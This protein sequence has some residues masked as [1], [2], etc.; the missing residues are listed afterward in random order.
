MQHNT[1]TDLVIGLKYYG[2]LCQKCGK[3]LPLVFDDPDHPE[4]MHTVRGYR[5]HSY[6]CPYCGHTAEYH[7]DEMKNRVLTQL[8]N[9]G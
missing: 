7:S 3:H 8:P 9:K 2:I 5:P 4:V 6:L 1:R